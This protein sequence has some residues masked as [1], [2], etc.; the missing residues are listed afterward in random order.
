MYIFIL[1]K[2]A[3]MGVSKTIEI[4]I[5]IRVRLAKWFTNAISWKLFRVV[6]NTLL[7]NLDPWQFR[8][9]LGKGVVMRH[10]DVDCKSKIN[11]RC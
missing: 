10:S 7:C 3:Y 1:V 2:V 8:N 6:S 4:D 11:K 9:L 5:V